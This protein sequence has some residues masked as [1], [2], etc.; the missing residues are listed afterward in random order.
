[1]MYFIAVLMCLSRERGAVSTQGCGRVRSPFYLKYAKCT[2]GA[3]RG[4][5]EK[6]VLK[7]SITLEVIKA[8]VLI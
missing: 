4:K 5:Q 7:G 6:A 3:I 8:H 1:M 2:Q